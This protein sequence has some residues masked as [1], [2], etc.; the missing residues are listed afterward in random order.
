MGAE[1]GRGARVVVALLCLHQSW[2]FLS[3]IVST[4]QGKSK[5]NIAHYLSL[6]QGGF[7]VDDWPY[8]AR[9]KPLKQNL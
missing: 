9:I 7:D 3:F 8:S 2:T 1:R 4:Y 5:G 6:F